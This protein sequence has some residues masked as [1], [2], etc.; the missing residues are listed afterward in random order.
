MENLR[1][2][3]LPRLI[4]RRDLVLGTLIALGMGAV[5][6]ALS[7]GTSLLVT[8]VPGMAFTWATFAFLHVKR[9]ELPEHGDFLPPFFILLAVQ[10][11]HFVEEYL[12]GFR[13]RFPELY[14]GAPY[15]NDL[16]VTFNMIAYAV[17]ILGSIAA[18]TTQRRFLLIPPLFFI[19]YGAI[20]NAISHTFWSFFLGEYFPGLFTAQIYW[21]LGPVVLVTLVRS[22]R[23][24]L[25]IVAVFCVVLT[26]LL[27]V[28]ASPLV[29][30]R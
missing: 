7:S 5:F 24:V 3:L 29:F 18:V 27:A 17:F 16:F 14:D 9:I 11:I 28:F 19:V 8:F 22:R 15:S 4:T 20:G 26:I 13:V 12:T 30:L 25:C 6:T 23:V 10:L 1:T 21:V 2:E